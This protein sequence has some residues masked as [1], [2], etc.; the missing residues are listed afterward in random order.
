[1]TWKIIDKAKKLGI[2]CVSLVAYTIYRCQ[3]LD[4]SFFSPLKSYLKHIWNVWLARNPQINIGR[5]E[6]GMLS[7][8]ASNLA[9]TPDNIMSG[10]HRIGIWSLNREVL[11]NDIGPR[12]CFIVDEDG[13]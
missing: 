4:V 1:M 3:S 5:E 11:V 2:D 10:F 7:S 8:K 13:K 6:L 9:L 12:K